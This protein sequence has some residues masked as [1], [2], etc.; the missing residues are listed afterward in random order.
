MWFCARGSAY[1]IYTAESD[2]GIAWRRTAAPALEVSDSGWDSEM[3]EYPFVFDHNGA[4]YMLYAGNGF[5]KT[6]FGIA[7]LD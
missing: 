7:V 4:R 5:G 3:V 1:R 2:D 6:G